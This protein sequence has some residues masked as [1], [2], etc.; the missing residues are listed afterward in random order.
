MKFVIVL[1]SFILAWF[2]IEMILVISNIVIQEKNRNIINNKFAWYLRAISLSLLLVSFLYI[3]YT[4]NISLKD[5]I[6]YCLGIIR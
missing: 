6:Q 1:L 2:F 3:R 4:H 5:A